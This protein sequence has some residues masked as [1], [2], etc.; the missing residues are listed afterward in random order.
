M[1]ISYDK[2]VRVVFLVQEGSETPREATEE[3]FL[4][5][6]YVPAADRV[7]SPVTY[8]PIASAAPEDIE[9]CPEEDLCPKKQESCT[10]TCED[11]VFL[12]EDHFLVELA[13]LPETLGDAFKDTMKVLGLDDLKGT[14]S[15]LFK[16][17]F[18]PIER[19][20]AKF[21]NEFSEKK[22]EAEAEAIKEETSAEKTGFN[23]GFKLFTLDDLDPEKVASI[24]DPLSFIMDK[25]SGFAT[26]TA[27]EEAPVEE[28]PEFSEFEQTVINKFEEM[29][30]GADAKS[31]MRKS[32]EF[33]EFLASKKPTPEQ[34]KAFADLLKNGKPPFF[35]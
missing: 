29:G 32:K 6:G 4:R 33:S 23:N 27:K 16:P 10:S 19:E 1:S 17:V 2:N 28:K 24:F 34:A 9:G 14:V 8:Q 15:D 5:A 18:A 35:G 7:Q 21:E 20:F 22:Q 12:G 13:T 30:L 3:D 25:T 31:A 26:K 11:C